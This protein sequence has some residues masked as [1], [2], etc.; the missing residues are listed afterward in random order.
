MSTRDEYKALLLSVLSTREYTPGYVFGPRLEGQVPN[1]LQFELLSELQDEGLA[2]LQYGR[3]WRAVE[4]EPANNEEER[5][6]LQEWQDKVAL[7]LTILSYREW[8]INKVVDHDKREREE[9]G[10][11]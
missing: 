2:E 1:E 6:L 11:E 3:G 10:E 5:L 8:I 9:R 7:G 4:T